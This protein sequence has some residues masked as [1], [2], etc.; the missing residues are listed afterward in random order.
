MDLLLLWMPYR[1]LQWMRIVIP[2]RSLRFADCSN[3]SALLRVW[4]PAGRNWRYTQNL[5]WLRYW[6]RHTIVRDLRGL[7]SN[8]KRVSIFKEVY[9]DQEAWKFE[10]K[11]LTY[12][13]RT[14]ITMWKSL[15]Y[16]NL[17]A[18]FTSL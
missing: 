18:S 16:L 17:T 9:G 14:L 1:N 6:T 5:A 11:A 10:R 3:Q 13:V 12:E 4:N 8:R 7:W 2:L 15:T